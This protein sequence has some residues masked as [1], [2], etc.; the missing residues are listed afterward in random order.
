[1]AGEQLSDAAREEIAEAIR[2]ARSDGLHVHK[3]Y[4]EFLAS[5]EPPPE[6]KPGEGD[7]PPPKDPP[8]DPPGKKKGRGIGVWGNHDEHD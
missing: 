6:E 1:M 5:Q 2:I 8:A 3:T 7:P 4:K